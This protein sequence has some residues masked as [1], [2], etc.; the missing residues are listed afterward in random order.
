MS[1][2]FGKNR[3]SQHKPTRQERQS[4]DIQ[5]LRAENRKLRKQVTR[6]R[7]ELQK[8]EEIEYP[9]DTPEIKVP[10]HRPK[11]VGCGSINLTKPLT[12]P[13]GK[14]IISCQS[15]GERTISL[16]KY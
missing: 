7:K 9:T 6:L 11:C 1:D 5:E 3:N 12:I 15:C 10:D 14:I 4:K 2:N 8:V 16:N 13:S